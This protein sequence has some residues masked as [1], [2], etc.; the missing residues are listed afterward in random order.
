MPMRALDSHD[1]LMPVIWAVSLG[2]KPSCGGRLLSDAG[3]EFS[4]C[5]FAPCVDQWGRGHKEQIQQGNE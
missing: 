3:E 4:D 5:I 2:S 1:S